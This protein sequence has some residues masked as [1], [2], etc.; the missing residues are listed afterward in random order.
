[1]PEKEDGKETELCAAIARVEDA[2]LVLIGVRAQGDQPAI[3]RAQRK[4]VAAKRE[5]DKLIAAERTRL[6]EAAGG[7]T[8]C[9]E[10]GPGPAT[11]KVYE[12][13][14]VENGKVAGRRS[15]VLDARAAGL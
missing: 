9:V 10:P 14:R 5:R 6:R 2:V 7:R 12:I 4:V 1:M 11:V 8:V 13:V 3:A 15:V